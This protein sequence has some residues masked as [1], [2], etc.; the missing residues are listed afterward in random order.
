MA[1]SLRTEACR[2]KCATGLACLYGFVGTMH[3]LWPKP[4]LKITPDWVPSPHLVILLTGLCEIAG[5]LGI[6]T[7]RLQ[8][9][10]GIGLALYAVCVFPANIKHAIDALSSDPSVW[11]WIYHLLRLPLQPVLIWLPLFAGRVVRW[12][13]QER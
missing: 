5:A 12:P 11:E 6:V 7:A 8:R 2:R 10:A 1:A 3:L 13:Q 9:A 4:F